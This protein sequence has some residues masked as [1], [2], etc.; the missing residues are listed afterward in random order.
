MK[1]A[2]LHPLR[3]RWNVRVGSPRELVWELYQFLDSKGF[4]FDNTYTPL[5]MEDTPIE[6]TATFQSKIEGHRDF[7]GRSLWRLIVGIILCIT[8]LLIPVGIWLIRKSKHTFSDIFRLNVEGEAYRASARSQGPY[9]SQSEVLDIASSA[10]IILDAEMKFTR[11]GSIKEVPNN[12]LEQRRLQI[13]FD[14]LRDDLDELIPK[15]TLP[16]VTNHPMK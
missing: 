5:K 16:K 8:V 10:R 11:A 15:I 14:Q 9:H 4:E 7:P 6:G 12:E 1:K 2:D 3:H 13:D